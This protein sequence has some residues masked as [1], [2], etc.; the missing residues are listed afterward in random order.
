MNQL[1]ESSV[2]ALI[3]CLSAR[4]ASSEKE[5]GLVFAFCGLGYVHEPFIRWFFL[6]LLRG[7]GSCA[8][9]LRS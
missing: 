7:G 3:C 5:L 2:C 8:S 9:N 4:E 1:S 6:L